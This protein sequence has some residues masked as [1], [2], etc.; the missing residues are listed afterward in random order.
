MDDHKPPRSP[1]TARMAAQIPQKAPFLPRRDSQA[2]SDTDREFYLA[3]LQGVESRLERVIGEASA[4]ANQRITAIENEQ[5]QTRE[6]LQFLH[7]KTAEIERAQLEHGRAA[8]EVRELSTEVRELM[9]KHTTSLERDLQQQQQIAVLEKAVGQKSA[10]AGMK[11]GSIV[12]GLVA[13]IAAI[14]REL[15]TK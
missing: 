15:L 12:A 11:G 13:L 3:T 2:P 14:I 6:D 5:K 1:S 7:I 10:L 8:L 9:R 4:E